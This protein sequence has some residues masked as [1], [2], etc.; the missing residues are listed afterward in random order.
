M[1]AD[2]RGISIYFGSGP[3]ADSCSAAKGIVIRSA[4]GSLSK[5]LAPDRSHCRTKE[6]HA[7]Q[8]GAAWDVAGALRSILEPGIVDLVGISAND[9]RDSFRFH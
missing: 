1:T 7:A 9:R 8:D 6:R 2:L 3:Q 5:R 4:A